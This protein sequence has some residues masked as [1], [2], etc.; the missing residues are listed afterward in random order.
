M[1]NLNRPNIFEINL[2]YLILGFLLLFG[3]YFVQSREVYSGLLITEYII[4]LLPNLLYLKIKG[5]SIKEAIRFNKISLKQIIFTL[6]I[7]VFSYPIAVFLNLVAITILTNFTPVSPT[8]VPIPTSNGEYLLGLFV[9]ALA[10]GICEEVM[11]RGTMMLGY[12]KM[13]YKKS[14]FITAILFGIFHFNIMNLLGPTFLGIILGFLVYKTNS[15]LSSMFA[16]TLNNGIALTIGYFLTKYT[17]NIDEYM[18]STPIISEQMQI[19]IIFFGVLTLISIIVVVFLFKHMPT[20]EVCEL[21]YNTNSEEDGI[22]YKE[23]FNSV[24]YTPLIIVALTFIFLNFRLL[25]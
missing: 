9:I 22:T 13:G 10:P 21:S 12:D 6:L 14:I 5:Y 23:N 11:F 2:F 19:S 15:I 7:I 3:G 17:S 16:H 8:T 18:S 24:K 1:E 20:S 4:I 25:F